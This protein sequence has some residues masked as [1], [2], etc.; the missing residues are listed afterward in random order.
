MLPFKRK[1]F[2]DGVWA[3]LTPCKAAE[4]SGEIIGEDLRIKGCSS[5]WCKNREKYYKTA[6]KKMNVR[7]MGVK[8]RRLMEKRAESLPSA[9]GVKHVRK[10]FAH[11]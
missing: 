11:L 6:A 3:E 10:S 4:K 8:A 5:N 2:I 1:R 9:G 7:L